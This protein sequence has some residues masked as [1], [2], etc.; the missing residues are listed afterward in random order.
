MI[1]LYRPWLRVGHETLHQTF[2]GN[3]M[4]GVEV[5]PAAPASPAAWLP[6]CGVY[7]TAMSHVV[8]LPMTGYVSYGPLR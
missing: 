5:S 4:I 1:L 6:V 8:V 3:P 7:P 2:K